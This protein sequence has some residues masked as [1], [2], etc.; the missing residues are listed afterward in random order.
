M[1]SLLQ[2][3]RRSIKK[4]V[5][6]NSS[7]QSTPIKTPSTSCTLY[8]HINELPLNKWIA[9][10]VDG[11][12]SAL[13]KSGEA[14]EATLKYH[15]LDL[16][17]QYTIAMGDSETKFYLSLYRDLHKLELEFT[18]IQ[19]CLIVLEKYYVVQFAKMLGSLL[20]TKIVLDP[21]NKEQYD[22]NLKRYHSLSK[23]LKIKLD[24]KAA[25]FQ[26]MQ[27]KMEGKAPTRDYYIQVLVALSDHAGHQLRDDIMVYEFCYRMNQLKKANNG[28][29]PHK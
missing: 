12:L 24:L 8:R 1:P 23:A 7:R 21:S 26:T 14:D 9:A 18:Q 20:K 15:L 29:R 4:G 27:D 22:S 5:S 25:Q 28:R 6:I 17:E 3:L 2:R 16:E 19:H 10:T 13:V 11:D